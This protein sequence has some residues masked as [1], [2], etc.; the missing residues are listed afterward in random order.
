[1]VSDSSGVTVHELKSTESKNVLREVIKNGKFKTENLAQLVSYMISVGTDKGELRYAYM[2]P[3][4]AGNYTIK[5]ERAFDIK[6]DDF[7]RLIID[8]KPNRF[9][10][11]DQMAHTQ[12]AA[13][14]IDEDIIWDRPINYAAAFGSPCNYCA[15][16]EACTSWDSGVIESVDDFVSVSKQFVKE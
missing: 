12:M 6:I 16:K 3:D 7:G 10:V 2:E 4:A 1:V 13:K 15:F 5:K 14:C 11:Y 9:T 8:G